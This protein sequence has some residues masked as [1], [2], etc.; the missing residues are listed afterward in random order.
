M[1]AG[2]TVYADVVRQVQVPHFIELLPGKRPAGDVEQ[3]VVPLGDDQ[4]Y[5]MADGNA[6]AD[7]LVEVAAEGRRV[8]DRVGVLPQAPEQRGVAEAVEGV[9]G[10][11]AGLTGQA[12]ASERKLI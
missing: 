4:G 11:F 3:Q 5:V 9:R 2:Q 1:S 6:A 10:S 8:D 12:R 7:R